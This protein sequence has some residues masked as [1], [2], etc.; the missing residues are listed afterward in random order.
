[1]FHTLVCLLTLK[2]KA[3]KFLCNMPQRSV[4]TLGPVRLEYVVECSDQAAPLVDVKLGT[5]RNYT[6]H[7]ETVQTPLFGGSQYQRIQRLHFHFC[8]IF[9]SHEFPCFLVATKRGCKFMLKEKHLAHRMH[10]HNHRPE[11]PSSF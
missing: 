2:L 8:F 11:L 9:H 10:Q 6:S 3:N 5:V 7:V 1:M 4:H